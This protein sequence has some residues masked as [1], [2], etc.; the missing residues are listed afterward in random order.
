M[1]SL[2]P[3]FFPS[4]HT[5]DS[6]AASRYSGTRQW[7][8]ITTKLCKWYSHIAFLFPRI[9]IFFPWHASATVNFGHSSFVLVFFWSFIFLT[10]KWSNATFP[11][12]PFIMMHV[13][14]TT[15]QG[16]LWIT[17]RHKNDHCVCLGLEKVNISTVGNKQILQL[18]PRLK[19]HRRA[20]G[21]IDVGSTSMSN[22]TFVTF[23]L[24]LFLFVFSDLSFSASVSCSPCLDSVASAPKKSLLERIDNG[25]CLK[26]DEQVFRQEDE[27]NAVHS[28]NQIGTREQRPL[29]S[30]L[31]CSCWSWPSLFGV[32][33]KTSA[34]HWNCFSL[35]TFKN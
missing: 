4:L 18:Q 12:G 17:R 29:L 34:N 6:H 2:R 25:C 27:V 5:V 31:L 11:L 33:S 26:A 23:S 14:F 16:R 15:L 35:L 10:F 8:C 3:D 19:P 9:C 30:S 21:D 13:D 7:Q 32:A 22:L 1:Y 28:W 20:Q 24:F